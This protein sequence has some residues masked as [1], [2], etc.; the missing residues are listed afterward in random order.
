MKH[1]LDRHTTDHL[2]TN[3]LYSG[4]EILK[5]LTPG[6]QSGRR[7]HWDALVYADWFGFLRRKRVHG[8]CGNSDKFCFFNFP[9]VCFLLLCEEKEVGLEAG[10]S[11]SLSVSEAEAAEKKVQPHTELS[12][13]KLGSALNLG[14]RLQFQQILW[15]K[16]HCASAR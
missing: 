4:S 6:G 3:V 12:M 16:A 11:F 13:C 5:S 15:F 14:V 10:C 8:S 9:T 1:V 2:A 7:A